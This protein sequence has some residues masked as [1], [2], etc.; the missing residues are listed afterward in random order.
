MAKLI[1]VLIFL[2]VA[3][4]AGTK[5][6]IA[7]PGKERTV[8][9]LK[10]EKDYE[11]H[12][13]PQ[14]ENSPEE[15]SR[16][17]IESF[18]CASAKSFIRDTDV[19]SGFY[20]VAIS[21]TGNVAAAKRRDSVKKNKE[22]NKWFEKRVTLSC[23][24]APTPKALKV[25]NYFVDEVN[26]IIREKKFLYTPNSKVANIIIELEAPKRSGKKKKLMGEAT[27]LDD[28]MGIIISME[29]WKI[30]VRT[31]SKNSGIL[32]NV[33]RKISYSKEEKIF[34]RDNRMVKVYIEDILEQKIRNR[35]ILHELMHAIG[36]TGHSPFSQSK[37]FPVS[38][39]TWSGS[40]PLVLTEKSEL[41]PLDKTMI[42]IL[43]RPTLLPGMTIQEATPVLN[44]L[45][46]KK[47]A[48]E[49]L[50][51]ILTKRRQILDE[52]KKQVLKEEKSK[53]N[54]ADKIYFRLTAL[55][56]TKKKLVREIA[57]EKRRMPK[58]NVK[59]DDE[60]LVLLLKLGLVKKK[61]NQLKKMKQDLIDTDA[62]KIRIKTLE[63]KIFLKKEDLQVLTDI[64]NEWNE[65]KKERHTLNLKL[66]AMTMNE[67]S[68]KTI[69]RR[70]LRQQITIDQILGKK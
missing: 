63:R 53:Y 20:V 32:F 43:Y 49:E 28:N 26:T 45:K 30:K 41:F 65:N 3:P 10:S 23:K 59:A 6:N 13:A 18:L 37:L 38:L 36:F 42:E 15:Y 33:S 21:P 51:A 58:V 62:K 11:Y 17:E 48:H 25:I 5:K 56:E 67:Q 54:D 16:K 50:Q 44:H 66:E 61:L 69:L 68:T 31:Y 4:L 2:L 64:Q 39:E 70:I 1:I 35:V 34:M 19:L 46:R 8:P 14:K 24:G 29:G 47:Y 7:D 55:D 40:V 27:C 52:K 12:F 22:I 57:R 9:L 60:S